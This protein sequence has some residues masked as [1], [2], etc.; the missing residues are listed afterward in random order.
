MHN[1]AEI[2]E[3]F[4]GHEHL[5]VIEPPRG[6]HMLDWRELWAYR[7]LLWVLTMRDVKVRY[8]QTVLGAA[9]AI[10]RPVTTMV[11]FSIVFG[12]IGS[13]GGTSPATSPVGSFA[14]NG[15]GL[16]DMAGNVFEWC[17]DLYGTPYAG[18]TDPRGVATGSFRVLRGGNWGNYANYARCAYRNDRLP[19][20]A[21]TER[22]FRAVLAPG[23]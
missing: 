7:E 12:L 4:F 2:K 11:I 20:N 14:A 6:W 8:K 1:S 9:W 18:G 15:Y 22:G 10:I 5:T 16:H 19:V 17:W 21:F 23:Q 3:E 13:V